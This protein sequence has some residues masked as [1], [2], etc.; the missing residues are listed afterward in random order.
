MNNLYN[1]LSGNVPMFGNMQNFINQF[2]QFKNTFGG[3]PQQKVQQMLQSGQI[4]QEQLNK[5]Q[6][7]AQQIQGMMR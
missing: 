4:T 6:S 1:A 5:A 7:L 3:D 2:N